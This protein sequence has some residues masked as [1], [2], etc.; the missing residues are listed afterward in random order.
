MTMKN[1]VIYCELLTLEDVERF[2][3]ILCGYGNDEYDRPMHYAQNPPDWFREERERE[4]GEDSLAAVF[5]TEG[6]VF[7]GNRCTKGT[8]VD[9]DLMERIIYNLKCK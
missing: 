1:N 8:K 9:L 5:I 4:D 2:E 6:R 3:N 7:A